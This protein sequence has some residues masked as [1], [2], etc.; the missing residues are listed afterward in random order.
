[1]LSKG[2]TF[3]CFTFF[4]TLTPHFI[5]K[6]SL[7]ETNIIDIAEIDKL[8]A[9][10]FHVSRTNP[11]KGIEL[12]DEAFYHASPGSLQ[13]AQATVCKGA[14]QVW[15]GDYEKA[16]KNLFEPLHEF[17]G[18]N[19]SKFEA[20]ALYHIFCAF[21]FLADYDNALKYASDMLERAEKNGNINAQAN[22]LNGIGSVYYTS[23]EDQKGCEEFT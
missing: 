18:F 14:C 22:A 20:H 3:F 8:I 23:G 1:M 17:E 16:L 21:Y 13:K 4:H 12:A 2:N 9:E 19:D 15:L 7:K 5:R 6:M 11:N 10:S